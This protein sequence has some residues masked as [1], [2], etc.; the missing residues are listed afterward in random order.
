ML[1]RLPSECDSKEMA[2][3]IRHLKL[4]LSVAKLE[5]EKEA[6]KNQ[7]LNLE[8]EMMNRVSWK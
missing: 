4:Q 2:S 3:L 5:S 6:L 1:S 7:I 8:M